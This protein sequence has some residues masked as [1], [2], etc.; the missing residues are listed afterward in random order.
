MPWYLLVSDC[1]DGGSSIRLEHDHRFTQPK[2]RKMVLEIAGRVM[3]EEMDE[4][5][6]AWNHKYQNN[7]PMPW[8]GYHEMHKVADIL[9]R[10]H[11]F[12]RMKIRAAFEMEEFTSYLDFAPNA[13]EIAE[14][15]RM[16][17]ERL[18]ETRSSGDGSTTHG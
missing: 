18:G 5:L 8:W 12:R 10:D 6:A 1:P 11:G 14:K 7:K 4:H 9:C 3:L 17:L 15:E 13:D 2:F 16:L